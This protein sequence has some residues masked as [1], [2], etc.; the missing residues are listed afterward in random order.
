MAH[1]ISYSNMVMASVPQEYWDE[2]WFTFN[3][4]KGYLQSFPGHLSTRISARPLENGDVRMFITTVWRDP[5]ELEE[6]RGSQ[7]S[8]EVLIKKIT[9]GVYDIINEVFEDFS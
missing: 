4:W 2:A 6:W 7:Y 3:S 8:A 9:K 1:I 5:E